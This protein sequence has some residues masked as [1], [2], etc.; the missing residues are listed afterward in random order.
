MNNE[1]YQASYGRI[2][3]KYA[4]DYDKCCVE[5]SDSP[6]WN[7]HQ[8]SRKRGHGPDSAYCKQHAKKLRNSND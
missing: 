2:W 3:T 1:K 6:G 8:C 5:V 4:T 7:W